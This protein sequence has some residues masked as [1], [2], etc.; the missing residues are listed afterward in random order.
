MKTQT[1]VLQR[2]DHFTCVNEMLSDMSKYGNIN[3]ESEKEINYCGIE[4]LS[5]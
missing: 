5:S 1:A 2:Q 4:L 3:I